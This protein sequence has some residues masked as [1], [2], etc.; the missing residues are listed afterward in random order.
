MGT[1]SHSLFAPPYG[2][3]TSIKAL[4]T[5]KVPAEAVA[6]MLKKLV[7]VVTIVATAGVGDMIW[8]VAVGARPPT[9]IAVAVPIIVVAERTVSN[10]STTYEQAVAAPVAGATITHCVS[11]IVPAVPMRARNVNVAE[12]ADCWTF[13]RNR[14]LVPTLM[15]PLGRTICPMTVSVV[16][17]DAVVT[18]EPPPAKGIPPRLGP[19]VLKLGVATVPASVMGPLVLPARLLPVIWYDPYVPATTETP[20]ALA[21]MPPVGPMTL[22]CMLNFVTDDAEAFVWTPAVVHPAMRQL[23]TDT[24]WHPF[25]CRPIFPV[26]AVL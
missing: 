11:A 20:I 1:F 14:K 24:S 12:A 21:P 17:T 4:K 23:P 25:S 9:M 16:V 19:S 8:F 5:L 7:C 3:T 6:V 10:P 22:F 13:M 15:H 26:P 2:C 18:G